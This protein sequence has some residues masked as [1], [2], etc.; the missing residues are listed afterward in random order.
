LTAFTISLL[1]HSQ[2]PTITWGDEYKV[3]IGGGTKMKILAADSSGVYLE[4]KGVAPAQTGAARLTKL[5]NNLHVVYAKVFSG[6]FHEKSFQAFFAL[7]DKLLIISSDYHRKEKTYEI[8]AAEI[9][10]STGE[11]GSWKS[12]AN[13]KKDDRDQHVNFKLMP[14]ADTTGF[15]IISSIASK[16]KAL[17][18]VQEFDKNLTAVIQ[19]VTIS[20]EFEVKAYDLEDVLYTNDRKIILVGKVLKQKAESDLEIAKY[21]IRIYDE[22]GQLIGDVNTSIKGKWLINTKVLLTK[23]NELVLAGFFSNSN[24]VA[25][26][27]FVVMRIDPSTGKVTGDTEKE[28]NYTMVTAD[29]NEESNEDKPG[30]KEG[31]SLPKYMTFRNIFHT[32]DG[33]LVLLAENYEDDLYRPHL[34][35]NFRGPSLSAGLKNSYFESGEVM[36][37]KLDAGDNI[38]WLHILPK[39]QREGLMKGLTDELGLVYNSAFFYESYVPFYC[40]FGAMQYNGMINIFF[41]D[42]PNNANVLQP[43]QKVY[44]A[45]KLWNSHCYRVTLNEVTGKYER[46]DFFNN[47]DAP[48]AMIRH[49]R[50]FGNTM[51][52]VGKS[53][54]GM[55]KT[56]LAVAKITF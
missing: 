53:P 6:E 37:C 4:E 54:E 39:A 18:E 17:Y 13:F 42:N 41:N 15:V 47:S 26:D 5:D 7:Q 3:R 55:G 21:Y 34:G 50:V 27:G 11:L 30:K 8:F 32:A 19:P 9:N 52:V 20:N 33:G 23:N 44:T 28:L 16:E 40:G 2:E 29:N 51:Y 14:N 25:A 46:N 1:A 49:A 12:I 38:S 36:M 35:W 10:G 56:K 45:K 48:T 43:G 31:G 22:H 24:K